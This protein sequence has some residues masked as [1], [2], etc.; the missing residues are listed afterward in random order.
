MSNFMRGLTW[1][2]AAKKTPDLPFLFL[3]RLSVAMSFPSATP[4]PAAKRA[5][6][7]TSTRARH[8]ARARIFRASRFGSRRPRSVRTRR[9]RPSGPPP[10]LAP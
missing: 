1:H 2:D 7:H 4:R 10:P 9:P 8:H 6:A 5:R 3:A